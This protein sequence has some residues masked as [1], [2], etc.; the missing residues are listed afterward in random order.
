MKCPNTHAGGQ[1]GQQAGRVDRSLDTVCVRPRER[2]AEKALR[3]RTDGRTRTDHRHCD[4]N[5]SAHLSF[6]RF[7]RRRQRGEGRRGVEMGP[8]LAIWSNIWA[9]RL[10]NVHP[11]PQPP[12]P[13]QFGWDICVQVGCAPSYCTPTTIPPSLLLGCYE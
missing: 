6:F 3:T 4:A 12:E 9:E 1:A 5:Y 8:Y 7:H 2:R 10:L 13:R 11:L